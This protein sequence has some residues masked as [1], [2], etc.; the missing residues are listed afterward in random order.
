MV[1]NG[2]ADAVIVLPELSTRSMRFA[3][4]ELQYH[5]KLMTGVGLPCVT[6]APD[7]AKTVIHIGG[8]PE[9]M[10]DG[11]FKEQEYLVMVKGRE[12]ILTGHENPD[13]IGEFDYENVK[14]FPNLWRPMGCTHAVYDFLEKLGVRWY[15]P[16]DIGTVYDKSDSLRIDDCLIRRVPSMET[17]FAG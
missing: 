13:D 17:R 6:K 15:L 11:P 4:A 10:R 12:I 16:T 9:A 8:I 5:V 7:D 2:K 14:T 3:A 1:T